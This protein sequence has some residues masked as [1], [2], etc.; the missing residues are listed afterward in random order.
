MVSS[1]EKMLTCMIGKNIDLVIVQDPDLDKV[2][3]DQQQIEQIVIFLPIAF[4]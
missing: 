3:A 1:V 4:F 2:M